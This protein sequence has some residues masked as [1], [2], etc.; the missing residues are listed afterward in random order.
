MKLYF[1]RFTRSTRPRWLLEELGVPY[2][3]VTVD[4]MA[5]GHRSPEYLKVHPL[6][7][8]P[9]LEDEGQNF[10]ESAALCLYLADR[11]PERGLAPPLGTLARGPYFQWTVYS[12]V[13]L[14]PP[15]YAH[16]RERR[17]PAADP[18]L[19][20]EQR[21]SFAAALKPFED[22]I[23]GREFIL[24]R[25]SAADV[26]MG[27]VLAWAKFE[28]LIEGFPAVQ[29]YVARLSARPAFQRARKAD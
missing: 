10:F 24:D 12:V 17:K 8:L 7:L 28:T 3:L 15:L 21:D 29:D 1:N 4:I 18:T 6:G 14:E 27:S 19:L 13:T 26:M 25:I 16:F 11:F 2:E 9:A 5:L 23:G 20:T 22:Y